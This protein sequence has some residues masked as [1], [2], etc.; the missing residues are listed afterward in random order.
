MRYREVGRLI[1]GDLVDL[2]GFSSYELFGS[3]AGIGTNR[4]FV[5][6]EGD[7]TG[8]VGC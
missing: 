4:D 3:W 6:C 7:K 8:R 1:L 5:G 2:E